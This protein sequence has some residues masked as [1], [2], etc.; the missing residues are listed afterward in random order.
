M[1]NSPGI[2]SFKFEQWAM[3][4]AELVFGTTEVLPTLENL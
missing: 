1:L 2:E 3:V 4:F